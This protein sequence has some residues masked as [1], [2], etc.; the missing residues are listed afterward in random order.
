MDK[1]INGKRC[2]EKIRN[3]LLKEISTLNCK[4]K[5][6]VIRVG[7]DS[8]S[9][10]YINNKRKAC[11]EVGIDFEE[12]Y[13]EEN[14]TEEI[15]INK[16]KELNNDNNITSILVQLPL[17]K[18]I[19]ENNI[20][21]SINYRKDV[22]GLTTV[23]LGK[24]NN[25]EKCIVPC[26]A[27]GI[28]MLFDEY[29]IN[30]ESKNVVLI[31]RSK[32]VGKPLIPLLLKKNAT[33]SICHSKTNNLIDYTKKA[34]IIICAVGKVNFINS[35]MIKN[36]SIIIDVGINKIDGKLYGDVNFN[37]V[38]DKV[39]LI[40]P[41]PG[42]VGVMTVTSVISNVLDCYKLINEKV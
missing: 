42:G 18:H 12:V 36:N 39:K 10:I 23:N 27:K 8:S 22:D 1:I 9:I 24:L 4:L 31:G 29:K 2:S 16:I 33:V 6:S 25:N 3:N 19:N 30:L 37:N 34:D 26:T 20:I 17:P 28:M 32:L 35:D 21:N 7:N 11:N 15:I 40:T 13:F 5:L 14:T 38:Y 41:V